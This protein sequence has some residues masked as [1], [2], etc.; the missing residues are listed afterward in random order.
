MTQ[1]EMIREIQTNL[2]KADNDLRRAS[3][4]VSQAREE[5]EQLWRGGNRK[6]NPTK[7]RSSS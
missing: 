3:V 4:F 2:L 1:Q 5:L 6:L 7:P